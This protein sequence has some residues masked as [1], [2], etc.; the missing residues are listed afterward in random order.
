M[1]A[2]YAT[3]VSAPLPE[4]PLVGVLGGVGPMATVYFNQMV[5]EETLA[6]SDQEHLDLLV[7]NHA[8]MPDRTAYILHKSPDSPAPVM[9]K[10]AKLLERAGCHFLVLPCNT[11]HFFYETV[12]A[13]VDIPI[14][15]I[16][17]CTLTDICAKM[18]AS[19]IGVLATEGTVAADLYGVR[20]KRYGLSCRYPDAHTQTTIQSMIYGRIK[21]GL[22]V[23]RGFMTGLFDEMRKNGCEAIVL[24]CTELSV[25]FRDLQLQKE[26]PDVFDSLTSLVR[27]TIL[28]AGKPL[29]E[30]Y[31]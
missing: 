30:A 14:L 12:Q 4:H 20:G 10:D 2:A 31:Q 6:A 23:E 27:H 18:Q 3:D 22:P 8:T 21:A 15:H 13:A 16:I 11:A 26:N 24:G 7:Y 29:R 9:I 17:D 1:T 5:L 28:A 25:A 19:T